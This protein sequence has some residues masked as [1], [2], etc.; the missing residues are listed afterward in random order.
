MEEVFDRLCAEI[1]SEL[2]RKAVGHHVNWWTNEKLSAA[3][4]RAGFS[5]SVP[6]VAGGSVAP[7]MRDTLFFDKQNPTFSIFVD[8]I[9]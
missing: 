7:A 2:Q 9:C 6:N 1:D 4:K 3:L 5:E 8:G